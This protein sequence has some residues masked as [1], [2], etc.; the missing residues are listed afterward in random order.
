VA[1]Y[2]PLIR[3][4]HPD[5]PGDRPLVLRTGTYPDYV[6]TPR[7]VD[8]DDADACCLSVARSCVND[9]YV[10]L[11]AR[12]STID[13][14]AV[15]VFEGITPGSYWCYYF[16][17]EDPK[18]TT[19]CTVGDTL[20]SAYDIVAS[21]E[22][23]ICNPVGEPPFEPPPE[24]PPEPEPDEPVPCLC[25]DMQPLEET[26]TLRFHI[27]TL[28][29]RPGAPFECDVE[30]PIGGP[31]E[32]CSW[33]GTVEDFVCDGVT[34]DVAGSVDLG[35][36]DGEGDCYWIASVTVGLAGCGGTKYDGDEP[37]GGYTADEDLPLIPFGCLDPLLEITAIEVGA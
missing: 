26:Y 36:P 22:D 7:I 4:W 20:A 21:C 10:S 18:I 23:V 33:S 35:G 6:Y 9:E 2:Q 13:Y 1:N 19:P 14:D 24:E 31:A 29:G 32:G 28:P 34:M 25:E 17:E 15:Y 3:K 27:R 11:Y 37:T 5:I 8:L 12:P 30:I 16:N